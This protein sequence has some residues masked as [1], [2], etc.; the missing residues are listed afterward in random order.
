[1]TITV[2]GQTREVPDDTRLDT[3]LEDLHV[4]VEAVAVAVN[5]IVVP[6]RSLRDVELKPDDRVE[7]VRAVGGG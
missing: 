1:M 3:L 5:L 4:R 7:V 6:R 2:N